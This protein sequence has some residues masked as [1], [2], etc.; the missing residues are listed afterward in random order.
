MAEFQPVTATEFGKKRRKATTTFRAESA[1]YDARSGRIL[2]QLSN[3]VETGFPVT[4]I[5]GLENATPEGLRKI[6]I[7]GRGFGLHLPIIDADISVSRLFA[8]LLGSPVMEKAE[9]RQIASRSNG[10]K[11]GRPKATSRIQA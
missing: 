6:E 7:Q 3:G 8:D 11:G 10:K 1:R 9:R 2:V 4:S 5:R